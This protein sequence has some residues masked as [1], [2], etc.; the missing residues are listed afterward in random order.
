MWNSSFFMNMGSIVVVAW[1]AAPSSAVAPGG[2]SVPCWRSEAWNRRLWFFSF[3]QVWHPRPPQLL[4]DSLDIPQAQH[5]N[6]V[7]LLGHV[8]SPTIVDSGPRGIRREKTH[9]SVSWRVVIGQQ[10]PVLNS[11]LGRKAKSCLHD[12]LTIALLCRNQRVLQVA[13]RV[14]HESSWLED[15]P[16]CEAF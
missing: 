12:I 11:I 10:A 14:G 3:F 16:S 8:V 7:R 9:R 1:R 13:A 5:W 4:H 6:A 15:V 2:C